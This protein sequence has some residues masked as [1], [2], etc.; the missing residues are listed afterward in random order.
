MHLVLSKAV[1]FFSV[2]SNVI[3]SLAM[4]ALVLLC[5]RRPI[6]AIVAPL[7]L[8]ALL[9]ATLSPLGNALLTPLE[10]RFP[11]LSYPDQ[12][13]DGIIVLGGSYDSVSHSY[14]ST[15]LLEEDTE[16]MAVMADLARRYPRARIIFSGGTNP[17][18][19]PG[20]SEAAIVKQYFVSFG[21]AADRISIEERSLTTEE[22][23]RFTADLVKPAPRS[24]WLLVTSSFH[25]PRAM[26]TFRRAGFNVIAFP[27]G[28]RTHG[29]QEMWWPAT[30]ATD[31][32]RRL[33]VAVHE[34][35]GLFVYRLRGYSS[36]W[37][38]KA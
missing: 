35:L 25:M 16:P 5:L 28:S 33:D 26:G 21:I 15:I 3:A 22:N 18:W 2:P 17:S 8:A 6:G 30:T 38:P 32:L 11:E 14:L 19:G 1:D 24:R 36:E 13:I 23:A 27:A 31:N 12:G 7:A 37:F 20:P 29:W 4:L 10:Q 34:W 9:V